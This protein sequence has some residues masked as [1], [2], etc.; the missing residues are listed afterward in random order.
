TP[1]LGNH[2]TS[3]KS[4]SLRHQGLAENRCS[5]GRIL[6]RHDSQ[7]LA[8]KIP[9]SNYIPLYAWR[10]LHERHVHRTNTIFHLAPHSQHHI[11]RIWVS[12]SRSRVASLG[13]HIW[14]RRIIDF[15][16]ATLLVLVYCFGHQART[17]GLTFRP[18][19]TASPPLNSS[20][21]PQ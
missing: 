17:I 1:A 15:L 3:P 6:C 11:C 10:S 20:V 21:R 16:W 8:R 2:G 14:Q 19:R 18:R 4:S 12:A 13:C 9:N 7:P 5:F